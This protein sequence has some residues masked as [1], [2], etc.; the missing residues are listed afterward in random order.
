MSVRIAGGLPGLSY[1]AYLDDAR[2]GR[3]QLTLRLRLTSGTVADGIWSGTFRVPSISPGRYVLRWVTWSG[4]GTSGEAEVPPPVPTVVVIGTHAPRLRVTQRPDPVR[5]NAPVTMVGRL[6]DSA[7]GRG[8]AGVTVRYGASCDPD[9]CP[10][11]RVRTD[12]QGWFTVPYRLVPVLGV[13]VPP[14][15]LLHWFDVVS[16]PQSD[17]RAVSIGGAH[18]SIRVRVTVRAVPSSARVRA[19]APITVTGRVNGSPFVPTPGVWFP[20]PRCTLVLQRLNGASTWRSVGSAVM[21]ASH[22]F[23]LVDPAAARGRHAYRVRAPACQQQLRAVSP[24]F[25]VT[26]R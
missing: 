3:L 1:V 15:R 8:F 4:G 23:T 7:T 6:V 9:P 11:R 18:L 24:R 13:P 22:R 25:V 26:G 12:R 10:V 20:I 16:A 19:G 17:G 14:Q 21:R 2:G 5:G